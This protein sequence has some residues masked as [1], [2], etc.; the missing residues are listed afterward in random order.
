MVLHKDD[1]PAAQLATACDIVKK[2]TPTRGP[3]YYDA[4]PVKG[5]LGFLFPGQG[6]Q[7][8]DMGKA[9]FAIFPEAM[10]ALCMAQKIYNARVS[11]TGSRAEETRDL[12]EL[13]F[14][15]PPHIQDKSVSETGL[16]HTRA[17]QVAIGA[18]SLAMTRV[19]RRFNITPHM[20]CGHSF[21]ELA[22]MQAAGWMDGNTLLT[23][24]DVRGKH[25][26]DAGS[27]GSDSGSM[28]AVQAPLAD[29]EALIKNLR[30]D[31]VL[32]NRNS[33]NQGV[34]SGPVAAA[35]HTR[36]VADAAAPF[37]RFVADQAIVPTDISVL[38]NTTGSVYDTDPDNITSLLGHQLMH[39]VCFQQNIETMH[40]HGV[41]FFIEAGPKA[42][43]TGLTKRILSSASVTAVS[44][45]AS[46][47]KKSGIS[48]LANV[49]CHLAA[50]GFSVDLTQ[51]EDPVARPAPKRMRV[52]LSGANPKPVPVENPETR[53]NKDIHRTTPAKQPQPSEQDP[54]NI[55]PALQKG[56]DMHTHQP[57]PT[58]RP[59]PQA[60]TTPVRGSETPARDAMFLVQKGL[61][62]MQALQAQTA[63]T[64]EKFL[65]TQA[66]AGQ[67]LADM[68][69]QTRRFIDNPVTMT[70][71]DDTHAEPVAS[72]TSQASP[73]PA[74]VNGGASPYKD[75]VVKISS[76]PKTRPPE[77]DSV[78]DNSPNPSSSIPDA[79]ADA[80]AK[81]ND[82]SRVQSVLFDT[83]SR[84]TGFPVEML[85]PDMDIES[86]PT[87]ALIPS[88]KWKS[89][90]NWKNSCPTPGG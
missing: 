12:A 84:L 41:D 79:A 71:P 2:G 38:S 49:L 9:L 5:K 6:S 22:A 59:T 68:M 61:E 63:R 54:P 4:G 19:L 82:L 87:W 57:A 14:A 39:P 73:V 30:L 72:R 85:E 8:P 46:G 44:L 60:T 89:F 80:A 11:D 29:I 47:G 88:K 53:Q 55:Q 10:E 74:R 56:P 62:A 37:S 64:H 48:D 36:L 86:N 66:M 75:A 26:A 78:Q 27:T 18:V 35:F 20:T 23:L 70:E 13:I 21:G 24:A 31:L 25:M 77:P 42:V 69:A 52:L 58:Q 34:L 43:L 15:P 76:A 83:V 51:W 81:A 90:Q 17:A 32:A 50:K 67:A 65:E 16:R 45:D 28:L 7:Y 1:D 40:D 3:V 33:P